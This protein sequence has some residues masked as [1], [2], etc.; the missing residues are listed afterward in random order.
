[1]VLNKTLAIILS[2]ACKIVQIKAQEV[3]FGGQTQN[4]GS[5]KNGAT[6]LIILIT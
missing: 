3:N 4:Y 2:L 1:M 5:N 6:S